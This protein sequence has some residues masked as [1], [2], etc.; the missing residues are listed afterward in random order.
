MDLHQTIDSSTPA[1]TPSSNAGSGSLNDE[2]S[3][4]VK[5]SHE[6][7]QP[8]GRKP[9]ENI[10]GNKN[11]NEL[12]AMIKSF[13][14]EFRNLRKEQKEIAEQEIAMLN[15]REELKIQ[16]KLELERMKITVKSDYE[17]MRW[18]REIMMTD[19]NLV[20][21]EEGKAWIIAK[22]KA[23]LVRTLQ[24]ALSFSGI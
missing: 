14:T 4:F 24:G 5:E 23:I 13:V 22:Q 11:C 3:P 12:D 8:S 15:K 21:T 2:N 6:L 10:R 7:P 17:Q 19:P 9:A 1:T 20:P 16:A 18:E